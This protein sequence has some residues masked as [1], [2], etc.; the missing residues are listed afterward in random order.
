MTPLITLADIRLYRPDVTLNMD[1]DRVRAYIIGAQEFSVKD[2]IGQALFLA[3]TTGYTSSPQEER[4]VKLMDGDNY[5]PCNSEYDVRFEG[6]KPAI[7]Y[8][9]V[10]RML[11]MQP[12]NVTRFGVVQKRNPDSEPLQE[13][14]YQRNIT[15]T[16]SQAAAYIQ[17]ALNYIRA[18]GK[19]VYPESNC[20][21]NAMVDVPIRMSNVSGPKYDLLNRR[22]GIKIT[23]L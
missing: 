22:G 16:V 5:K 21:D 19:D 10:A 23:Q 17:D 6:L 4:M 14:V 7:V 13:D 12:G 3:L 20:H 11:T 18:K 15:D 8:Y 1:E 9:S 2:V